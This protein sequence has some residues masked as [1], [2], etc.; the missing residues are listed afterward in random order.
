MQQLDPTKPPVWSPS[1]DAGLGCKPRTAQRYDT[2][3]VMPCVQQHVL[4][5]R[6][7]Y[8]YGSLI[9][10]LILFWTFCIKLLGSLIASRNRRSRLYTFWSGIR[11]FPWRYAPSCAT[12]WF[13]LYG[14]SDVS[15]LEIYRSASMCE[16]DHT[17]TLTDHGSYQSS[18]ICIITMTSFLSLR[19]GL[20][21]LG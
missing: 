10:W 4:L 3:L 9:A 21:S 18:R 12:N 6:Q 14:P 1:Q 7:I 11:P 2:A 15:Q 19:E 5:A 20:H 16:M 17:H 8:V 13:A